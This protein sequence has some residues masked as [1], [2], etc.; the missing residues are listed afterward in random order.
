MRYNGHLSSYGIDYG[1]REDDVEKIYE[2]SAL[3]DELL[4]KNKI[5]YIIVSPEE[6][7]NLTVNE[8]FFKKFPVVAE[9]GRHHVYQVK[10]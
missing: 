3:A 4:Q 1:P 6:R 9:V 8:D 2:G 10:K 7:S 5:E